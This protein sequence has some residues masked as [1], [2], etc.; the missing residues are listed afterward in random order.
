MHLSGNNENFES[1]LEE[2]KK[3]FQMHQ[4]VKKIFLKFIC[5][6]YKLLL[7]EE[8]KNYAQYKI[9]D[10]Y[11]VICSFKYIEYHMIITTS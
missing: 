2:K 5:F 7:E 8:G 6:I 4:V 10:V 1:V 9:I 3:R 11:H